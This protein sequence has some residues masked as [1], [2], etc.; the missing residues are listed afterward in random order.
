MFKPRMTRRAMTLLIGVAVVSGCSV[1]PKGPRGAPTSEEGPNDGLPPDKARHRVAL[2]VPLTGPGGELGQSIANATTMA[3]L[4]TNAQTVRITTYDTSGGA[5]DAARR[6]LQEGNRLILG[7]MLTEDI[8]SVAGVARS[9]RVP[10]ITFS[11]DPRAAAR[12]VFIMGTTQESSI[13]RVVQ[14]ARAKGVNHFALLAPKGEFGSRATSAYNNAV[15][16]AGGT[17]VASDSYD[18]GNNSILS[19]ASRLKAK[20][21]FQAVLI[22]DTPKAAAQAA[23]RL[24]GTKG[25]RILGTDLWSGDPIVSNS[26]ALRGAWFAALPDT[27]YRQF[28]TSYQSRF[29]SAPYRQATMGYD[30]VLLTVRI[31]REW[32]GGTPFPAA[33][34]A[35]SGGFLGLDG[36]FRFGLD[37]TVERALEVRETRAGGVTIVSPAP[38][39]FVD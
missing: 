12:D 28:A 39:K 7:P 2:L 23:T 20:G 19:A 16:I 14:F 15:R 3:I 35:D 34:L 38:E 29:G 37:G 17:V 18:R 5:G 4:D 1:I 36:P 30:A 22:A 6:A 26:A 11:S 27:R 24:R 8:S 25:L 13:L 10:L 33:R 9:A 32:R 21:G 31:A